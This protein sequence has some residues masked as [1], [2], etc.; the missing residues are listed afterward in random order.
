M[1][2]IICKLF[3]ELISNWERSQMAV[4]FRKLEMPGVYIIRNSV[5]GRIYVGRSF[6]CLTRFM[7][8]WWQLRAGEHH[9]HGLQKDFKHFGEDAFQVAVIAPETWREHEFIN[10]YR[11][12]D[13]CYGYNL[14]DAH[15]WDDESRQR[16]TERKLMRRR[17]FALLPGVKLDDAMDP[18]YVAGCMRGREMRREEPDSGDDANADFECAE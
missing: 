7:Q 15:G 17:N 1:H 13:P 18:L 2:H 16:D 5:S 9:N 3:C 4:S 11:T 6:D 8:H 12:C 10:K 14:Q